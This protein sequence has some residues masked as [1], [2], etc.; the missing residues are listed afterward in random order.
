MKSFAERLAENRESRGL[1]KEE[2]CDELGIS[3]ESY[4]VWERGEGL[5]DPADT[6]KLARRFRMTP[7]SLLY[8]GDGKAV[9]RTMFPGEGGRKYS[10]WSDVCLFVGAVIA[11]SG[12]VG[13]AYMVLTAIARGYNTVSKVIDYCAMSLAVFGG[14]VVLGAAVCAV[15][16]IKR[17]NK[18]KKRKSL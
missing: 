14:M 5:P 6:E 4:C 3:Y 17:K 1:S 13:G 18:K 12:L 9:P 10:P 11:L 7:A 16:L 2:L 15:I 8:G